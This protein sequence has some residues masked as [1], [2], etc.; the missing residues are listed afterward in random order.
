LVSDHRGREL[1]GGGLG[2]DQNEDRR[3]R[4]GFDLAG[5]AI[6][7]FEALHAPLAPA[8]LDATR[9]STWCCVDR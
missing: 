8:H 9:P 5:V 4:H 3:R 6:L 2:A 1:V 7:E